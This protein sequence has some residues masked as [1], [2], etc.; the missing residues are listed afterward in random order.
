[1]SRRLRRLLIPLGVAVVLATSGFAFMAV[2]SVPVSHAGEGAGVIS[3]YDVSNVHYTLKDN[4]D[5][6]VGTDYFIEAV[7]FELNAPATTVSAS[8]WNSEQ[9]AA[10]GDCSTS[11][12]GTRWTCYHSG[13]MQELEA[14]VKLTVIAGQ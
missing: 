12:G 8:V 5:S 14:A 9:A 1:M 13:N 4:G 10:Y 11:N 2:N 6:A 7:S 3:G